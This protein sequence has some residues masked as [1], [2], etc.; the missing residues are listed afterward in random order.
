[1]IRHPF[2]WKKLSIASAIGYRR[3]GLRTR[4]YFRIIP[5]SFND[6]RLIQFVRQLRRA[7]RGT[8]VILVWDGLPSHRSL[9]MNRYVAKQKSWLQVVRLPAYTP[10]INP[11]EGMWSN[12]SGQ[13]LANRSVEGLGEMTDSVHQ[14]LARVKSQRWLLS[15]FI[16]HAGLFFSL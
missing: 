2:R 16:R 11:V 12:I 8:K 10:E 6:E 1:M 3:D 7:F 15:S 9:K 13:E 14:G 4:L 5:G